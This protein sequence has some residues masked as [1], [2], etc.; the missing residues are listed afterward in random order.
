MTTNPGQVLADA[1]GPLHGKLLLTGYELPQGLTYEEWAEEGRTLVA[2]ARASMWWVGDWLA[3]GEHHF[4]DKYV[5]AVEAT[6]LALSTLKNAQWVADRIPPAERIE[7]VP[8]SHHRAVASL[9]PKNRKAILVEAR[10]EQLAE[11]EVR[12]R[13]R[14]VKEA[15]A[16]PGVTVIGDATP[17]PEKSLEELLDL[18][19]AT[20]D[21]ALDGHDWSSVGEARGYVDRA[22]ARAVA[23]ETSS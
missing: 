15:E 4:G 8:Y 19:L 23:T 9:D 20:L 22:R 14:E 12:A 21:D 7:D 6:G 5:Q 17:E 13:V 11:Y 3:Y 16:G 1:A 18:A 10:D 2:M